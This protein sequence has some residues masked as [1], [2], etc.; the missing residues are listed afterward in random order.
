MLHVDGSKNVDPGFEQL[1]H[2][3][4]AL[5]MARSG[6]V[7]VRQFVHQDQRRAAGEGGIKIE[8]RDRAAAVGDMP[9]RL[10]RQPGEECRGLLTTMG[11]C[12]ADQDIEPLGTQALGFGQ[13]G[14]GFTHA[15]TGAEEDF[16]LAAMRRGGLFQQAVRIRAQGL[17]GHLVVP[18]RVQRQI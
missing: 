3:L 1:F 8:L 17:V 6:Y 13:H 4:P 9:G 7:A 11:F 5:G 18:L 16:Q 14:E 2:I 15:R 12:H 10:R